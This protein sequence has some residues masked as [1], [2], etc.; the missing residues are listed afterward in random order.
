MAGKRKS[1]GPGRSSASGLVFILLIAIIVGVAAGSYFGRQHIP[2]GGHSYVSESKQGNLEQPE[3]QP[4]SILPKQQEN[5]VSNKHAAKVEVSKETGIEPKPEVQS[6]KVISKEES[7]A[8]P[9][10][11]EDIAKPEKSGFHSEISQVNNSENKIALTFD[12]GA[13]PVPTPSILRTLKASG[14]HATFFLTG[15]WCE[16]SPNLVRE[17]AQD[18]N[19]I[20][21][22][23]YSHPDLRKLDN[24]QIAQQLQKVDEMVV[25]LTGRSTKPFF[26]PPFGARNSHVLH[27]AYGQGYTSI[28]WAVDSWDAFK[29]NITSEEIKNRILSK[30]QSGD[31]ILMHC[32]SQPTAD[33]LPEII[34]ELKSRGYKMVTVS[35]LAD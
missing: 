17:I 5:H 15:K 12:A 11:G 7:L 22:H 6:G 26:R 9:K 31:I 2:A 18:G 4:N 16:K 3:S 19:E 29:K 30:V 33:A 21:N 14:I 10:L 28:Y 8:E 24:M 25:R 20:C 1:K 13:S 35:E 32:G 27:A 23:T 34:R